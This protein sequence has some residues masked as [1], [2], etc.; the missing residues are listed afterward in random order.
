MKR[1]VIVIDFDGHYSG[2]ARSI[3]K[4]KIWSEVLPCHA[5]L[6]EI[7]ARKPLALIVA[8]DRAALTPELLS[9]LALLALGQE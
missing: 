8:G 4:L 1:P 9:R 5:T 3:R 7:A 6:E 2:L